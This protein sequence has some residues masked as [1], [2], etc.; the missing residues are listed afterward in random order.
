MKYKSIKEKAAHM[1]ALAKR[2]EKRKRVKAPEPTVQ[3]RIQ[4]WA[5]DRASEPA[6][7][8]IKSL[9][10]FAYHGVGGA[11]LWTVNLAAVRELQSI[12]LVSV[13]GQHVAMAS[14]NS[15]EHTFVKLIMNCFVHRSPKKTSGRS[16]HLNIY[17]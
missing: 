17:P 2:A 11:A 4:D 16:F 12:Q 15:P 13:Y 9:L 14:N 5:A 8:L 3:D 7:A 10:D 1:V 6:Q